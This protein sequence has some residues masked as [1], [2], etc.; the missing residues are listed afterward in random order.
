MSTPKRPRATR[1]ALPPGRDEGAVKLELLGSWSFTPAKQPTGGFFCAAGE[2]VGAQ[3]RDGSFEVRR[4]T[5]D[6]PVLAAVKLPSGSRVALDPR[7]EH[8]ACVLGSKVSL[9]D[10]AGAALKTATLAAEVAVKHV[11]FRKDG[12]R[13]WV[14]GQ[15]SAGF[16]VHA[17]DRALHL[18]FAQVLDLDAS[19]DTSV[20]VLHPTQDDFVLITRSNDSDDPDEATMA[21]LGVV[22]KAGELKIAFTEDAISYPCIGF[23]P[24]GA[25]LIGVD[26]IGV[27]LH[28]WPAYRRPRELP[29]PDGS[30]G[31]LGGIVVGAKLLTERHDENRPETT[32]S[33]LVLSLPQLEEVGVCP[34]SR[35]GDFARPKDCAGLDLTA[36]LGDDSFLELSPGKQG[37]W[38]CR[39]WRLTP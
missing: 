3:L 21:R 5:R 4:G 7:G 2:Y 18:D 32:S 36:A 9:T 14:F 1:Q 31:G 11:E 23:T 35:R 39:A 28:P 13:L 8:L 22:R 12:A 25:S 20:E 17:F 27:S 19:L 24:D 16:H 30:E 6:L 37:A 29:Q 26:L 33:L 34:W 15:S 38:T 10:L